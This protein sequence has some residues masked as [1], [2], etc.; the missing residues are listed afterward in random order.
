MTAIFGV[1]YLILMITERQKFILEKIVKEYTDFAYPVGSQL[2]EEK[3][4]FGFCPATIRNEMQKL[5]ES[6]YLYQ[7][8][9]SAGRVPTDKGYRFFVDNLLEEG[10]LELE[11]DFEANEVFGKER[12][13]VFKT[14]T[15]LSRF[16]AEA[17]LSLATVHLFEKGFF[18]KEG[19]E[20]LLRE[21][22]F[23]ERD[24]ISN[25]TKFLKKFEKSVG[26][27][28]IDSEI[29]IY[30]GKE[31]P[32]TRTKDFSIILTK[33]SF[34]DGENGIVSLLGPKRMTY[35]KNI[36]LINSITKTLQQL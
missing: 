36:S 15:H 23:E 32:F 35:E 6:G 12:E 20:E 5:T 19:W 2:L 13:D 14:I 30:I 29:E 27:F 7:P 11:D 21:P 26:D 24:F 33:C 4:D 17:S 28:D 10:I 25:F 9:T 22:E 8:H 18:W 3:Y 16:L 34:P 31:N 1:I